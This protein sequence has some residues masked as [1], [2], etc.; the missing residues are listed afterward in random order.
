MFG[1]TAKMLTF[2]PALQLFMP[3]I[4][5]DLHLQEMSRITT[6]LMIHQQL[7]RASRKLSKVY[8]CLGIKMLA[9]K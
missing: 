1:Q 6:E 2:L 9:I 7:R 5:V 4:S 8:S 3:L